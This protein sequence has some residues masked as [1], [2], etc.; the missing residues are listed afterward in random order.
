MYAFKI[1]GG[2]KLTG[3]VQV[4]GAKNAIL[5]LMAAALLTDEPVVLH[6]ISYLSDVMTLTA[7]LKSM[8]A[9]VQCDEP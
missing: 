3:T 2:R 8:G 1:N 7:L 4:K 9:D 6:N 5:P